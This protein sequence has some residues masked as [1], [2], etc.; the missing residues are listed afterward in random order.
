[1]LSEIVDILELCP[2]K[3]I[4]IYVHNLA[5]EFQFFREMLDWEKVFSIDL[6]KPIYGVTKTGLEFRCS[7]L[8]SGYSLAKLGEQL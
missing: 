4:I 5:Y 8:L 3:R 6:R 2:K 7:Y 1:M